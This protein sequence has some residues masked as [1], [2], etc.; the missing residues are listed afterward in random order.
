M[1][2]VVVGGSCAIILEEFPRYN[3]VSK[4]RLGRRLISTP[5]N[6]YYFHVL[7]IT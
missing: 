1:V 3:K 5:D 6:T 2:R 7:S 4:N